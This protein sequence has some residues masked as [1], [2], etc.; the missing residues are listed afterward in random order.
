[1][2]PRLSCTERRL[3]G[4]KGNDDEDAGRR[5]GGR[6]RLAMFHRHLIEEFLVRFD[7]RFL[8]HP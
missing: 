1:M 7:D 8:R 5:N 6:A 4:A 3:N 2:L